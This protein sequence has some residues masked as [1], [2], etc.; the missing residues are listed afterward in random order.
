MGDMLGL[1]WSS[2]DLL[3]VKIL[4]AEGRKEEREQK[5][6]FEVIADLKFACPRFYPLWQFQRP[7][8][9]VFTQPNATML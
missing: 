8:L 5:V 4:V 7:T 6:L 2:D 9:S 1:M 3:S